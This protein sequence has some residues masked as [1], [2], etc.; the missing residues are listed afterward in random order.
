M[1]RTDH[2]LVYIIKIYT[3]SSG[4]EVE[5][6][7]RR[8]VGVLSRSSLVSVPPYE[9]PEKPEVHI[10]N[11]DLAIPDAVKQIIDYLDSKGYLPP[12]QEDGAVAYCG[13]WRAWLFLP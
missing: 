11:V 10:K 6:C 12:K 4:D 3:L 7:T 9:A 1:K 8:L 13:I 2:L 5:V